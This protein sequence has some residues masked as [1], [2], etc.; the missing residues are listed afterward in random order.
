MEK[1]ISKHN[2][3]I[4]VN[5]NTAVDQLLKN[6]KAMERMVNYGAEFT[7]S[8]KEDADVRKLLR[9]YVTGMLEAARD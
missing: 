3:K 4:M 7:H 5:T 6:D 9:N 2:G 8:P 1:R